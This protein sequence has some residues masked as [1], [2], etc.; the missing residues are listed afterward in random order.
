MPPHFAVAAI[1]FFRLFGCLA[2]L[3]KLREKVP[4]TPRLFFVM[5]HFRWAWHVQPLL[6][7][8]VPAS[9]AHPSKANRRVRCGSPNLKDQ[10]GCPG[11]VASV[12]R[13]D[14]A[15]IDL[16]DHVTYQELALLLKKA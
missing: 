16:S 3:P 13:S 7:P 6:F 5:F 15:Q 1:S 12:S 14:S 11:Y 8:R 10:R 9:E 2:R 4:L